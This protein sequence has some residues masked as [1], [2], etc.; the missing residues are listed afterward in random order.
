[1]KLT[2]APH[3]LYIEK[4]EFQHDRYGNLISSE[5]V[6]EYVCE[7]RCDD[8][9]DSNPVTI[10]G[11]DFF[12]TYHIVSE[13]DVPIGSYVRVQNPDGTKRAFGRVVRITRSNYFG[14]CNLYL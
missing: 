12:P 6:L 1:M 11:E 14:F 9:G 3:R 10:N 5:K 8:S 2:Y 7:C 13:K 4:T